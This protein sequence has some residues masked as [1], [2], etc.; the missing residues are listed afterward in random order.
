MNIGETKIVYL[1]WQ[2]ETKPVCKVELLEFIKN[3]PQFI[4]EDY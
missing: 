4:L 1:D 2:T 3:G